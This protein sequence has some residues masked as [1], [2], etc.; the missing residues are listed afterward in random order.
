LNDVNKLAKTKWACRRGMLELDFIFNDFMNGGYKTLTNTQQDDFLTFL[1][2]ADPDL[3][4]WIMGFRHPTE[5]DDIKMVAIIQ[6]F[7]KKPR[8]RQE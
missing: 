4:A 5:E 3:F 7:Q 2:N 6:A 8:M 1:L